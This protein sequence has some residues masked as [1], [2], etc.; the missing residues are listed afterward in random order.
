MDVLVL[1]LLRFGVMFVLLILCFHCYQVANGK[2][3]Q[4]AVT[5]E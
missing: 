2:H 3:F 1:M 4:F 5:A